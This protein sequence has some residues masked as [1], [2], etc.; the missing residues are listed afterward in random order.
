MSSEPAPATVDALLRRAATADAV[1]A[2][3][4]LARIDGVRLLDLVVSQAELAVDD[5]RDRPAGIDAIGEVTRAAIEVMDLPQDVSIGL[6]PPDELGPPTVTGW[7]LVTVAPSDL[8]DA[9]MTVSVPSWT[10]ALI[11]FSDVVLP[12]A[13]R[14]RRAVAAAADGRLVAVGLHLPDD[15]QTELRWASLAYEPAALGPDGRLAAALH[16]ALRQAEHGPA[17]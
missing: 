9:T 3:R 7:E 15:G 8:E 4:L 10:L 11:G 1:E 2:R 14:V 16:A 13:G 17:S 6:E 12:V 5:D